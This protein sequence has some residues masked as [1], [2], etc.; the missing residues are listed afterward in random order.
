MPLQLRAY[1]NTSSLSGESTVAGHQVDFQVYPVCRRRVYLLL[2]SNVVASW[3][4]EVTQYASA[5]AFKLLGFLSAVK[6][7]R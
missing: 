5:K 6:R 2:Q 4:T 1:C 3:P 7:S